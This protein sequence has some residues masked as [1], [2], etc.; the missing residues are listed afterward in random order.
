MSM[1]KIKPRM[2]PNKPNKLIMF[3]KETT[4]NPHYQRSEAILIFALLS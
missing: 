1:K 4:V 3:S 2:G